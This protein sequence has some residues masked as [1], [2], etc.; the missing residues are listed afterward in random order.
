ML[1]KTFTLLFYLKKRSNYLG[2]KLPIYMRC[3]TNRSRFEL[4]VKRDCEPEKWNSA[5]GRVAGTVNGCD[6]F[7][8]V[9]RTIYGAAREVSH[10]H[11]AQS[12]NG[13]V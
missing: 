4:A 10:A 2:G 12:L 3:T 9:G 5:S 6:A 7:G 13:D 8:F 11:A 1:S